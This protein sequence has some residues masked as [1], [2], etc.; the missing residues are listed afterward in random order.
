[1]GRVL[2]VG[3]AG[4]IGSHVNKGLFSRGYDTVVFDNLSTGHR[5]AVKWGD[6]V[7]GCLSDEVQLELLF[8]EYD[9]S[10]VLHF[11]AFAYVGESVE[12]P[13]KYYRNNVANTVNLLSVMRKY[14][15]NNF[16]FSS[17]CA[18][19]GDPEYIPIDESHPQNP[20]NPYGQTKLI[21]EKMLEDFASSYSEFKYVSL[22][23]FNAAGAAADVEIGENH[24]P[25]T[26]LI[27]L[28]LD[29]ASGKRDKI[30]VFGDDYDTEDGSCIRDYI[31][32][33]D[34]ANAHILA[35]EFLAHNNRSLKLNL[36][37]GKGYSVKNVI[38]VA[39][40][41]T[42]K[43]IV[44]EIVGRRPGDSPALVGSAEKA[45]QVLRWEPEYT[46]L[47]PIIE[48]AWKWHQKLNL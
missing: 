42:G 8:K 21:V 20:I 9:I 45:K 11:A 29:A 3:G 1:M 24:N 37:N 25:E 36:G 33:S 43:E 40:I 39:R 34:L 6:F 19:Y 44:S 7:L 48:T 28:V 18:T 41:V 10:S 26:H 23:Y 47:Q 16:I 5:D 13:E 22:R 15:V 32:V 14:N 30:L 46:E 31:H 12:D 35:L 4:Y 38:D 27:P 17:T 2:I